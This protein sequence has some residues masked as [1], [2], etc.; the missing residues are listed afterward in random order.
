MRE[1]VDSSQRVAP[2]SRATAKASA[3]SARASPSPRRSLRTASEIDVAGLA[4]RDV[5]STRRRRHLPESTA[6]R[7]FH[8]SNPGRRSVVAQKSSNDR[9]SRSDHSRKASSITVQA[10]RWSASPSAVRIA[11]P[12]AAAAPRSAC[13]R[14]APAARS[15]PDEVAER[16]QQHV[17][18]RALR[19]R[20]PEHRGRRAPGPAPGSRRPAPSRCRVRGTAG[21]RRRR[22]A[23]ARPRRRPRGRSRR[24]PRP[25]WPDTSK[26]GRCQSPTMSASSISTVPTSCSLLGGHHLEDRAGVARSAA[27]W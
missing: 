27:G 11:Y 3:S 10:A 16:L 6:I 22:P 23:R 8:G 19:H 15:P 14:A 25:C 13:P 9:R 12:P 7:R 4:V 24:R 26:L 5:R 18:R 17:R 21:A 1:S 20:H 2:C